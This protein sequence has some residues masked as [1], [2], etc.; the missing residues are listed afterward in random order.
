MIAKCANPACN[1]EFRELS[2]GRLFLLPPTQDASH[3]TWR[4]GKLADHCYWLCPE[5]DVTHTITRT[6][7]EVVVSVREPGIPYPAPAAPGRRKR[8]EQISLRSYSETA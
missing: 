4:A 1:R 7:S 6:E 5:C 2:K 3:W 8:P